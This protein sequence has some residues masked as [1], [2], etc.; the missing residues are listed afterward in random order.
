M[1]AYAK[2]SLVL[3]L[4]DWFKSFGHVKWG[5]RVIGGSYFDVG[6]PKN[7]IFVYIFKANFIS[8]ELGIR[9]LGIKRF[10]NLGI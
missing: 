5:V 8:L 9:D 7:L 3:K 1:P 4:H 2:N 10:R 6:P